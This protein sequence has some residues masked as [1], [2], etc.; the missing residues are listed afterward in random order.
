MR[1]MISQSSSQF[2]DIIILV[3]EYSDTLP[4]GH[5]NLQYDKHIIVL[6]VVL[7]D[8]S[9]AKA[10]IHDVILEVATMAIVAR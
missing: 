6:R 10:E 2:P 4:F 5:L 9:V 7:R 3:Y 1:N 8:M